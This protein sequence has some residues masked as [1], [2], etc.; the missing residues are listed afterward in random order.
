MN[1][2]SNDALSFLSTETLY[3]R[4]NE[5]TLSQSVRYKIERR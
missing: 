5:L 1:V 4:E 2:N 3:S